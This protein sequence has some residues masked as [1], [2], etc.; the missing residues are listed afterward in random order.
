MRLDLDRRAFLA[1]Y[2]AVY[3]NS[4]WIAAAV[5]DRAQ[6]DLPANAASL[7]RHFS[8]V[9]LEAG[10]A[11]QLDL[12]RAHPEL[13]AGREGSGTLTDNSRREQAGAGLDRC[14]PAEHRELRALNERYRE[15]FGF[16]FILAVQ[17]RGRAEILRIFRRRLDNDPDE[18]FEEALA[19]VFR[20]GETRIEAIADE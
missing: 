13:G 19:Q 12:L 20:I 17:G 7:N 2:G 14:R 5:Y 1:S 16:P 4:P 15:K 6:G 10:K 8:A 11:R 18:E 3:E 9:V